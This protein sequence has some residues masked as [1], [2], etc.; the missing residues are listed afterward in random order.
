MLTAGGGGMVVLRVTDATS[1][2]IVNSNIQSA[3]GSLTLDAGESITLN[4]GNLS[5]SGSVSLTAGNSIHE[6]GAGFIAGGLL[7]TQSS[8]GTIL[9]AANQVTAFHATNTISGDIS[10]VNSGLLNIVAISETG[11][12]RDGFAR[13]WLTRLSARKLAFTIRL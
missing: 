8:T 4:T 3:T 12:N 7:T 10:L 1:D 5:T 6:A 13:C 9:N 11:G 2:I